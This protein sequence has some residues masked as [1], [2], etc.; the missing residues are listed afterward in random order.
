MAGINMSANDDID[1]D[2]SEANGDGFDATALFGPED[3]K[4][5][6]A[7]LTLE[8]Q[9]VGGE[10]ITSVFAHGTVLGDFTDGELGEKEA[11]KK[12][13]LRVSAHKLEM[14]PLKVW[15]T[16]YE[17]LVPKYGPLEKITVMREG[18]KKWTVPQ[19]LDEIDSP[20]DKLPSSFIKRSQF[21][22]GLKKEYEVLVETLESMSDINELVLT[23]NE[24]EASVTGGVYSIGLFWFEAL[25]KGIDTIRRRYR[26]E[27][28]GDVTLLTY[29]NLLTKVDQS[30]FPVRTKTVK[31]N[32]LYELV[33]LGGANRSKEDLKA[34]LSVVKEQAKELVKSEPVELLKLKNEIE[35]VTLDELILRFEEMLT[36]KLPETTWQIF[37]EKNPF[38]LSLIFIYPIIKLRGHASVGGTRIDGGGEK[39]TDFLFRNMQTGNLALIEIKRPDT[40]LLH[41]N[42]PYRG[43]VFRPSAEISGAVTQILDQRFQLHTDFA[44]LAYKSGLKDTHPYA[45]HCIVIAGKT[46]TSSDEKKSL[47]L[48]RS[49]SKEVFVV[50]FDETLIKLKEIRRVMDGGKLD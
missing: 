22:F 5:G 41:T 19:T 24:D 32:A 1:D 25:R 44:A 35:L 29:A 15:N 10:E 17:F 9:E 16:P 23:D 8:K 48:F 47:E 13:V 27:A 49:S 43:G 7:E 40:P 30:Q 14:W 38:I 6:D 31:P 11:V 3:V 20:L 21:G 42:H 28:K 33:K 39:I 45:V 50:T 46:P 4:M 34:A 37:F 12:L 26:K 36:K 2:F 18:R